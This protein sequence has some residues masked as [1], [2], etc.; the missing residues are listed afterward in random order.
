M[1]LKRLK[2]AE[3]DF[4]TRYPGGF[5]H[6]EMVEIGKKHKMGKMTELASERFAKA[7]F[8][9]VDDII[10]SM[11][12]TVT[13]SSMVSVFEK[14]RFRDTVRSFSQAEKKVL[15]RGLKDLL[16]GDAQQGF[17][18]IVELLAVYKIAKWMLM[19]AL[20]DISCYFACQCRGMYRPDCVFEEAH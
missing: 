20:A 14:P 6:P 4:L 2:G 10:D 11:I 15:V 13:Q 16:H 17:Q 8:K 18:A 9:D 7:R 12:K 19:T 1:N 3:S 5:E